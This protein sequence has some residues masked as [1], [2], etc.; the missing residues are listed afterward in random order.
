MSHFWDLIHWIWL[1]SHVSLNGSKGL[2][3]LLIDRLSKRKSIN[4]Y[5]LYYFKDKGSIKITRK[6][7]ALAR[8]LSSGAIGWILTKFAYFASI[9]GPH[10][11]PKENSLKKKIIEANFSK[12]IPYMLYTYWKK[13]TEKLWAKSILILWPKLDMRILQ[14]SALKICNH[15]GLFEAHFDYCSSLWDGLTQ[16][17]SSKFQNN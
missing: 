11:V 13:S 10:V 14:R 7:E 4:D 17:L 9:A 16:Q 8:T 12:L 1:K 6:L 3:V 5:D 2:S 15:Y